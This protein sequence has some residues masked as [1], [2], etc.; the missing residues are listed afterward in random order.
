MNKRVLQLLKDDKITAEDFAGWL[1]VE[2]VIKLENSKE[3]KRL[4]A[5]RAAHVCT[6]RCAPD[7]RW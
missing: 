6:D 1:N 4:A 3:Y 2:N 5:E 7:C